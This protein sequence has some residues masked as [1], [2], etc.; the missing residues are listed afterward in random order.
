MKIRSMEQ[1]PPW[2]CNYCIK[3][4][5]IYGISKLQCY[6]PRPDIVEA[7]PLMRGLKPMDN[8]SKSRILTSKIQQ[9]QQVRPFNKGFHANL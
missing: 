8:T 9:L 5:V 2:T 3:V 7:D 6:K 1:T 4:N